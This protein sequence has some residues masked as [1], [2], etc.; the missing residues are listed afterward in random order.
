ME[1]IKLKDFILKNPNMNFLR[2]F[3]NIEMIYGKTFHYILYMQ[4]NGDI[5][6]S[7][8]LATN[9]ISNWNQLLLDHKYVV[10]GY[11]KVCNIQQIINKNNQQTTVFQDKTTAYFAQAI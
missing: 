2:L 4:Y 3:Y 5:K 8:Q 9:L 11:D 7:F 6:Q 10:V 1:K